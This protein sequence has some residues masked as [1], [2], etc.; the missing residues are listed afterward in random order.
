MANDSSL[1]P[2]TPAAPVAAVLTTSSAGT[3]ATANNAIAY[4]Y[5]PHLIRIV[6]AL[7]ELS[8]SMAFIADKIDN[9]SDK[10]TDLATQSSIQN[11][12]L[13]S[14]YAAITPGSTTIGAILSDIAQASENIAQASENSAQSLADM[15]VAITPGS[16]TIGAILSDIAQAS[17][18]TAR[19]TESM[20]AAVTPGSTTIGAILSDIAQA[21]ENSAVSLAG[22][23]DR[24]KGAGIHMKGPQDWIGLISTYKLYIENAG[25]EQ[26]SFPE[27]IDYFNKI[28][29]LPKDF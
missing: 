5:S 27:F 22:I 1:L 29:D 15:S 11:S 14:M 9:V 13:S 2:T 19:A 23:Y 21:S 6:T 20:T 3:G 25:P 4:D 26:V 12:I 8:L 16:T 24:S 28:K 7:E 18:D 17:E 10:L